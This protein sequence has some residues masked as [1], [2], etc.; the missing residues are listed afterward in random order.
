[1]HKINIIQ[2]TMKS[3]IPRGKCPDNV[4]EDDSVACK[5]LCQYVQELLALI[6]SWYMS[7][8]RKLDGT[9]YM[10]RNIQLLLAGLQSHLVKSKYI[11]L[12]TDPRFKPLKN[13]V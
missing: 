5:W 12:F 9:E 3:T 13:T 7:E 10:P 8:I 4:F 6:S 2:F 11:K 1:M